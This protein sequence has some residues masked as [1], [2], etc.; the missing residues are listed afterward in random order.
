MFARM[1]TLFKKDRVSDAICFHAQRYAFCT[2]LRSLL[3]SSPINIV[4]HD[5]CLRTQRC[6]CYACVF[7]SL[8]FSLIGAIRLRTSTLNRALCALASWI[9][10]RESELTT[11]SISV[12]SGKLAMFAF[13]LFSSFLN[14]FLSQSKCSFDPVPSLL[15]LKFVMNSYCHA[16]RRHWLQPG[17]WHCAKLTGNFSQCAPQLHPSLSIVVSVSYEK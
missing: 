11:L 5:I 17:I 16:Q 8:Y 6:V 13:S 4:N 1:L 7:T 12:I 9:C 15:A 10:S 2:R 3:F 14:S